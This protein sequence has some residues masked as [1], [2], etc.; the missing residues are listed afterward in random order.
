MRKNFVFAA[1]FCAAFSASA[2]AQ[3]VI[4]VNAPAAAVKS[5][6]P[7]RL[8]WNAVP[9]A[10]YYRITNSPQD[11]VQFQSD[12]AKTSTTSYETSVRSTQNRFHYYLVTAHDGNDH[13]I[14]S[15]KAQVGILADQA[16][17]EYIGRAI[18][19]VAG[20]APGANGAMF[21][22][23]LTIR[24][25]EP[26][27]GRIWFRRMGQ[28]PSA[29]DPFLEYKLERDGKMHWD[30][31]VAAMGASGIGYLEIIPDAGT[32]KAVPYPTARVYNQTAQGTFGDMVQWNRVSDV[33]DNIGPVLNVEYPTDGQFRLN[34][35]FVALQYV[36]ATIGVRRDGLVKQ[37][38][39]IHLVPG[40]MRM[41]NPAAIFDLQH[42]QPGDELFILFRT[43]SAIPFYTLTDNGTND[44]TVFFI[45]DPSK[46]N[47]VGNP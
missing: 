34:V 26:L 4:A 24:A 28:L 1:L 38:K 18:I 16:L 40:E 14:C 12:S 11:R 43:G 22:T 33:T 46:Q 25:T 6:D 30:D 7:I 47:F 23:A 10:L 32:T 9:G 17:A 3:C 20:S 21:K 44:P 45:Q 41:G 36:D 19:P 5:G 15:G 29:T 8:S 27:E 35:G 31:V 13:V 42:W 2:Y 39:V 37:S